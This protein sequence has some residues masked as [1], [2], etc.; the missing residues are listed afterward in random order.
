MRSWCSVDNM[1]V[2]F[3]FF[4]GLQREMKYGLNL[5]GPSSQQKKQPAKLPRPSALGFGDD[6]DD[7][8]EME[9]SRHASKN[10]ALKDVSLSRKYNILSWLRCYTFNSKWVNSGDVSSPMGHTKI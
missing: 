6:N 9:I 8:I 2:Q 5:R 10:K 7:D 3:Y 1:T 4:T